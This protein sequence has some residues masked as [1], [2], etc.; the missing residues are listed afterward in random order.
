MHME[1]PIQNQK[2]WSM[3]INV[4]GSHNG[5]NFNK[6]ISCSANF[7]CDEFNIEGIKADN[8]NISS[9]KIN[10]ISNFT[11]NQ[12]GD[13][14]LEEII[15]QKTSINSNSQNPNSSNPLATSQTTT[16]STNVLPPNTSGN[17]PL[18]NYTPNSAYSGATTKAQV[19]TQVAANAI[20]ILANEMSVSLEKREARLEAEYKSKVSNEYDER[21]RKEKTKFVTEFLPLLKQAENGDENTRMILYLASK[22]L[23][24]ESY[25]KQRHQ[26]LIQAIKNNHKDALMEG[27]KSVELMEQI[28]YLEIYASNGNVDAMVRLAMWYSHKN[29]YKG[30]HGGEN[31]DKALKWFNKAA[32]AGSPNA[33]YFLGMIYKYGQITTNK[34][35]QFLLIKFSVAKDEKVALD[36]FIKADKPEYIE[37]IYSR[38]YSKSNAFLARSSYYIPE[39][40]Y[41]T[42][43]LYKKS[44]TVK[45][46]SKAAEMKSEAKAFEREGYRYY[47]ILK[48]DY[49]RTN[50]QFS[51]IDRY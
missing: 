47:R 48:E 32:E 38:L 9:F 15:K 35:E 29:N 33:M 30:L 41:E 51:N 6:S 16:T 10:S 19:Y 28:D 46:E 5:G 14:Q 4:N 37:S 45:N 11:Y 50:E 7:T 42:Y 49:Y 44:K 23:G 12:G 25:V 2:P 17:D 43:L 22:E 18:A 39:T 13:P 21:K 27:L 3:T 34:Y 31:E 8:I 24:C 40:R 20:G 26:W 1:K 36:W